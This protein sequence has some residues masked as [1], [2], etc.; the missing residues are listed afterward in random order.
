MLPELD[1]ESLKRAQR[2][3]ALKPGAHIYIIGVC[4]TGT[5]SVA[6]LLKDLGFRVSGSDKAF[7][8]PMGDVVRKSIDQVF[9]DYDS[10]HLRVVPDLVLIGNSVSRD[11]VEAQH[12][13]QNSIPYASMPEVL[14]SLLIGTREQCQT[15]VVVIGTHGKTTTTAL[16]AS[17]LDVAGLSPGYFIGGMPQNFPSSIRKV[18]PKTKRVCVLEGDEYDSAFFAKWPKF[19][20]YRPDIL[21]VTSLEFDHGD[22]YESVE[23]I[24]V[25]FTRVVRRVPEGGVVLVCGETEGLRRLGLEWSKDAQVK[26]RIKWYG[27][28][29]GFSYQLIS[30]QVL[31]SPGFKDARQELLIRT[32][33]GDSNYV[34][35]LTGV[36][37]AQNILATVAVGKEFGISDTQLQA[38]IEQFRGVLRRQQLVAD[39]DNILVIEDF[40]HHPTAVET[41]LQ[42]IKESYPGRRLV[43]VYEPRSNTSKR[44]FFL[45]QYKQSFT[46]AD[47]TVILE[48]Q[49]AGGYSA[50]SHQIAPLDV[51]AIITHL[52]SQG[53]TAKSCKTVSDIETH[54]LQI[55]H[56]G[57]T[58]VIMS[59]GNFGNLIPTFI[60][61][62]KA[63]HSAK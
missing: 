16:I 21:V 51:N 60:K 41:T 39:I 34:S 40:A 13:L 50:T 15:S 18:D 5:A 3:S 48:V 1:E 30:R 9:E 53:K 10:V 23:E 4:G 24:E 19:H 47:V 31:S 45:E 33:D 26:A 8:P 7:Y 59:N 28:A 22:I 38:G 32:K 43:A 14:S 42:G 27:Q 11:N 12:V 29:K 56:P 57:D 52:I 63:S 35:T 6:I 55:T 37:N 49:D 61:K 20:S 62:L 44:G 17:M 2:V 58:V 46:P 54:L 36:H 25:E